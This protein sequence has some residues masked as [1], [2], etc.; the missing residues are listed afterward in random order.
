MRLQH[1]EYTTIPIR[2]SRVRLPSHSGDSLETFIHRALR[3][4]EE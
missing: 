4:K 3:I 2:N 1:L